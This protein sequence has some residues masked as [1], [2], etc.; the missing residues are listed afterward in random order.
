[1]TRLPVPRP[2]DAP[3]PDDRPPI[4][5]HPPLDKATLPD[6][7]TVKV[8]GLSFHPGY[9]D[10]VLSIDED[11]SFLRVRADPDNEYDPG[12]VAVDKVTP[13]GEIVML[14]HLPAGL[15]QRLSPEL[16]A[17][18]AWMITDAEVLVT[19]DYPDRP[20]LRLSLT[21]A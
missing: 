13:D 2:E 7:F 19:P 15:A 11:G 8:V 4:K 10:S 21:R 9:P 20:G 3:W 12:A 14:G 18:A 17:G 1:V 6:H 16:L 5:H